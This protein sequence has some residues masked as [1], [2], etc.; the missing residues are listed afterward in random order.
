MGHSVGS[1]IVQMYCCPLQSREDVF[2]IDVTSYPINPIRRQPSTHALGICTYMVIPTFKC[3]GRAVHDLPIAV[4]MRTHILEASF[5]I[6]QLQSSRTRPHDL[7]ISISIRGIPIQFLNPPPF[8]IV[9]ENY[10]FH[11]N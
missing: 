6:I 8:V 4:M 10:I 9:L 1:R 11:F 3:L 5:L 7:P 2:I